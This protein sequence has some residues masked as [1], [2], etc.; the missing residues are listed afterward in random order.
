MLDFELD[1]IIYFY[2]TGVLCQASSS[3]GDDDMSVDFQVHNSKFINN[4]FFKGKFSEGY[5]S[6]VINFLPTLNDDNKNHTG[7]SPNKKKK[8]STVGVYNSCFIG[9][10]G[11]S[12]SLILGEDTADGRIS[13]D[14]RDNFFTDNMPM[15]SD[16]NNTI[17]QQE[18]IIEQE[19]KEGLQCKVGF[20]RFTS[21]E[22]RIA[23]EIHEKCPTDLTLLDWPEKEMCTV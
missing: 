22:N 1:D 4:T 18:I 19:E 3:F 21:T 6:A 7:S 9:N 12:S 16:T 14:L 20:Q 10:K 17:L 8:K 2:G 23:L 5:T 13:Y 11:Y 15:H